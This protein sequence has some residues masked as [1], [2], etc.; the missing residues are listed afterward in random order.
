LPRAPDTM[1]SIIAYT[2]YSPNLAADLERV[3]NLRG[4]DAKIR[5][6]E[7]LGRRY[8]LRSFPDAQRNNRWRIERQYE[9][10]GDGLSSIELR[11]RSR[12]P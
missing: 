2:M 1:A 8:A 12:A 3:Q 9:N 7:Q 10:G 6:L 4:S 11:N 5:E